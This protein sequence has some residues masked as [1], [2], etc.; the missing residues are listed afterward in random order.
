M[1]VRPESFIRLVYPFILD[2]ATLDVCEAAID[3]REFK[4]GRK[5]WRRS[6]FPVS[7]LLPHVADYLN[8][9]PGTQPTACLWQVEAEALQSPD[10]LG[11]KKAA[12]EWQLVVDGG[13]KTIRIGFEDIQLA[14][15]RAGVGFLTLRVGLS[16]DHLHEWQDV[17]HYLRFL[18]RSR[19]HLRVTRRTGIDADRRPI[20]QDYV[21]PLCRPPA[22]L[23]SPLVLGDVVDGLLD[24]ASGGR[25]SRWWREVFVPHQALPYAAFFLE[26]VPESA[27][28]LLLYQTHNFFHSEQQVFPAPEDLA[29]DQ[30]HLL[31]YSARQWWV[32]SLDGGAFIACQTP[33]TAFFRE[34]LPRHID[35][36]Y[37][38]LYL[39]A[40]HQRFALMRLSQEVTGSWL[41][42]EGTRPSEFEQHAEEVF[43]RIRN[44]LLSFTARG[45]FA[46]VMQRRHHHRCYLRW[47]DVFQVERL[48]AE[49]SLEVREMHDYLLMRRTSQ[50]EA[51]STSLNVI[52]TIALPP[53][54]IL[55]LMDAV[56]GISLLTAI[57]G[58]VGG[59]VAG[60]SVACWLFRSHVRRFFAQRKR[61]Q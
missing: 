48:F 21:P 40:L 56:G 37:L 46:Q 57:S 20:V 3:R 11:M 49:V 35:E 19:V 6:E 9:P 60:G 41:P 26:D 50:V 61:S 2:G 53:A 27:D 47:L 36:Q 8:P 28:A 5:L 1:R 38:L 52:A 32:F 29:L 24:T 10:A 55:G 16:T 58:L 34:T 4:P 15:F 18:R 25:G 59:L 30:D 51:L 7:E 13:K 23:D 43:R 12:S 44:A 45:Y 17:L 22:S 31:P 39:L 42:L 54:L 14:L 33:D